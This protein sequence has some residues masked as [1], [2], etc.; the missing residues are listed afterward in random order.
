MLLLLFFAYTELR[1]TSR[2]C[3]R[4][5][6]FFL[7]HCSY[8]TTEIKLRGVILQLHLR[9]S[10]TVFC[11]N[12]GTPHERKRG[13]PLACV[14]RLCRRRSRCSS[15]DQLST[16]LLPTQC[17]PPL[18]L[19]D[20]YFAVEIGASWPSTHG[21]RGTT[22]RLCRCVRQGGIPSGHRHGYGMGKVGQVVMNGIGQKILPCSSHRERSLSLTFFYCHTPV[23]IYYGAGWWAKQA[24]M[25]TNSP[26]PR[27]HQKPGSK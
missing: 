17:L 8:R 10:C 20:R 3:R 27:S 25:E 12:G 26:G 6:P 5:E 11:W 1:V 14:C 13:L 21:G 22:R 4:L 9:F 16:F 18:N 7:T 2:L 15:H 24:L 19:F 23:A